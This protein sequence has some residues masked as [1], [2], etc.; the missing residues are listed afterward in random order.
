MFCLFFTVRVVSGCCNQSYFTHFHVA[1]ESLYRLSTLSSK[2]AT[3]LRSSFFDVY[4]PSVSSLRRKTLVLTSESANVHLSESKC[5][6]VSFD[7]HNTFHYSSLSQQYRDLYGPDSSD[8]CLPVFLKPLVKVPS[9]RII[10]C[11]TVSF[12]FQSFFS[13]QKRFNNQFIF[14]LSFIFPI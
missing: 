14:S 3:P 11:R 12:I 7:F 10:I 5:W 8:N 4:N 1:L 9:E 2:L 13:F 6:F